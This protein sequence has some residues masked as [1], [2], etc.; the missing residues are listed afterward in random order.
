MV[1]CIHI[2][3]TKGKGT[4]CLYLEDLLRSFHQRRGSKAKIGCL[5]SPHVMDVRERIRID[6]QPLPR[7]RFAAYVLAIQDKLSEPLFWP[8]FLNLVAMYAF[9]QEKVDIAILETGIGGETDSTNV[10]TRPL[11]TAITEVGLDHIEVLGPDLKDIAWHKGGIMKPNVPSFSVPQTGEVA[12]ILNARALEKGTTIRYI[13]DEVL[14]AH[15]VRVAPDM[16]YQ[17]LNASL[18]IQ[19][20]M[21]YVS[22][23]TYPSQIDSGVV[24]TVEW[25][26]LPA[27]FEHISRDGITW[28]ICSAHNVMSVT[29]ACE[30]FLHTLSRQKDGRTM[31]MFSHDSGR[32]TDGMLRVL[33]DQVCTAG[34]RPFSAA[35]F[36]SA[37]FHKDS[38]IGD[39]SGFSD[40]RRDSDTLETIRRRH[41]SSWEHITGSP[42]SQSVPGVDAALDFVRKRVDTWETKDC[43]VLVIGSSHAAGMCRHILLG[44]AN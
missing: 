7:E 12:T 15:D 25:T 35:V 29:K 18:A 1:P 44:S 22:Q 24:R 28:V 14:T 27:K 10:L 42:T 33:H 4:V 9:V 36:C 34:R 38:A 11:A 21:E 43:T 39:L 6:S 30:A 2:A 40:F 17:R 16:P 13:T 23:L 3:G 20:S 31:L 32:D 19:L 5:T 8:T 37:A 41:Q 26:P